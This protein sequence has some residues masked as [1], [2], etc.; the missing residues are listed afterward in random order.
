MQQATLHKLAADIITLSDEIRDSRLQG[1]IAWAAIGRVKAT[2]AEFRAEGFTSGVV[3]ACRRIAEHEADALELVEGMP[4]G[5]LEK[6]TPGILAAQLKR[7]VQ[8]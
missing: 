3:T 6:L 1:V 7:E 5:R 4:F 2:P 8:S